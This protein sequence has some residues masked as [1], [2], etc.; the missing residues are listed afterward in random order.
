LARVADGD[1]RS[2]GGGGAVALFFLNLLGLRFLGFAGVE[3]S[4]LAGDVRT[5]VVGHRWGD[6]VVTV[7]APARWCQ[8][9]RDPTI[10]MRWKG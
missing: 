6:G 10:N 9:M 5:S 1:G 2:W 7:L 4:A 3:G 8:M